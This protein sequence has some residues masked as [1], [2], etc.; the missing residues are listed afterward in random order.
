[1]T[2]RSPKNSLKTGISQALGQLISSGRGNMTQQQ[3]ATKLGISRVSVAYYEAGTQSP[4]LDIL[5]KMAVLLDF[6]LDQLKS[7]YI[8]KTTFEEALKSFELDDQ[9][10]LK[11]LFIEPERDANGRK[12][13]KSNKKSD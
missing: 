8:Q 1:M 12:K 13:K 5:V 6:S 9:A 7:S 3:L 11:D 10:W 4:P 2:A